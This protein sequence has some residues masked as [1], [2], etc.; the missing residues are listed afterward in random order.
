MESFE[1]EWA[2]GWVRIG[3]TRVLHTEADVTSLI[4]AADLHPIIADQ[5]AGGT[6]SSSRLK[7]QRTFFFSIRIRLHLQRGLGMHDARLQYVPRSHSD[8]ISYI[9]TIMMMIRID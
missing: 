1:S 6:S 2:G 3:V 9:S 4:S 7:I 8:A 5:L